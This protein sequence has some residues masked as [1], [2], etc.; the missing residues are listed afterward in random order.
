MPLN[1]VLVSRKNAVR[2]LDCFDRTKQNEKLLWYSYVFTAHVELVSTLG[3]FPP[4]PSP[5][6]ISV[7][8]AK[9][10][11]PPFAAE[12]TKVMTLPSPPL[13]LLFFMSFC[14]RCH[15]PIVPLSLSPAL[16]FFACLVPRSFNKSN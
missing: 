9:N 11:P 12:C 14:L 6:P 2:V 7:D 13:F 1:V 16:F 3:L 15:I 4:S 8:E 10:P 5:P